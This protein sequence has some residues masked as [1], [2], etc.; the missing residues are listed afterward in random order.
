MNRKFFSAI[1]ACLL[2][3]AF[4]TT[5]ALAGK[6]YRAER[7]DVQLD[8]QPGGDMLVT[9][10]VVFRFEGGPFTYAF[11]EI[12]AN[13]TDGLTFLEASMDGVVMAQGTGAGQVEVQPGDPLKAIWHFAPTSDTTHTFVLRYRVTGVVSTGEADTLRWYVIPPDHGYPIDQATV[14][15]N[16]PAGVQPLEAPTLDRAFDSM[17]S[18]G[19]VRL[20][21]ASIAD[22]ESVILTATFPANSLVTTPPT[23][24]AREQAASAAARRAIPIGLLSGLVSLILGGLGLLTYIRANR[25]ELNLP[26]PTLLPTPPDDRLP[27]AV[28]G[29]LIGQETYSPTGALFDLAQRGILQIREEKGWLGAK[30][31]MLERQNT[32]VSLPPHEQGMLQAL[33]KPGE[34]QVDM[35]EIL[36]RLASKKSYFYEPLE[37]ELIGRGW[38]D[39]ER[40]QK[41]TM[42]VVVGVLSMFLGMGMFIGGAIA[43][44]MFL[45]ANQMF[46]WAAAAFAGVGGG[47][48]LLSLSL[49]IYSGTYSLLTPTGEEQKIRWK[50]FRAYLEQVSRGRE[51]AIRPDTFERYLAFAAAFGLG[52]AWAK[53]FQKLGGAPLPVWFQSL[54][55]SDDFSAMVAVMS[56]ADTSASYAGGDGGGGASGGGSS[57]AG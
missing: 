52:E 10:T 39:R 46:A 32:S 24:Q 40:K 2:L 29:K 51:P 47:V 37:Q 26:E 17:Q 30:K 18:D 7:F 41:R 8:L 14:W 13:G 9:E 25:R 48:F 5:T 23:W 16:Y 4:F 49:I 53:T 38:L 19:G 44:G 11:R 34:A 54:S 55:G 1:L 15:L 35:S 31:F 20:T 22:D 6:T 36:T 3:A 50:S 57:G 28:A 21:T 42:L 33:F 43:T 27:P 45:T 56:A 12:S